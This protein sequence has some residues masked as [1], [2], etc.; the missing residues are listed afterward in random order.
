MGFI[1]SMIGIGLIM[2]FLIFI[3]S[4]IYNH[5]KASIDPL[6]K[7]IKGWFNKDDGDD[8]FDQGEDFDIAFRGKE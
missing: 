1:D 5:E 8:F 4:K 3:F 7:K 6:I 2:A